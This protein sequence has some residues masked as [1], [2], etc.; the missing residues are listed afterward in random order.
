M[1][2]EAL[3]S[4]FEA[5]IAR[6]ESGEAASTLIPTF[7]SLCDRYRNDA[8]W[9]CLAWLYLLEGKAE[10]ALR[11]AKIA[12]KANPTDAQARVNLSLAM[13]ETGAKGVRNEIE[14][15][16][17]IVARDSELREIVKNNLEEGQKRRKDWQFI[18][19]VQAWLR[20]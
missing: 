15:I 8:V 12:V 1:S 6:Y 5:A 18:T 13:L 7:E 14:A 20:E 17:Q 16:K 9:T 10:K 11:A 3:K 4:E 2:E 19:R